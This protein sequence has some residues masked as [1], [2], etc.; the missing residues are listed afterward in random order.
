MSTPGPVS[1]TTV[2]QVVL[3]ASETDSAGNAVAPADALSWTSDDGGAV[4]TLQVS[5]DSLSC[6]A[7]ATGV[8]TGNV[9]VADPGAALTS[10]PLQIVVS[11]AA[12]TEISI[13]AGAPEDIG[14]SA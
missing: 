9:T 11:A 1:M 2:Q 6:T 4:L 12:A 14:A 10:A 3:T 7:V 5:A 13:S 8:G